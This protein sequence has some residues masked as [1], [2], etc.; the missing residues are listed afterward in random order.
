MAM[1]IAMRMDHPRDQPGKY[2]YYAGTFWLYLQ[3]H[4]RL[5]NVTLVSVLCAYNGQWTLDN[6]PCVTSVA[7][8]K[9]RANMRMVMAMAMCGF[10]RG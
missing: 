5:R 8:K 3:S 1:T 2:L 9:I 4:Y 7:K 10:M 6:G